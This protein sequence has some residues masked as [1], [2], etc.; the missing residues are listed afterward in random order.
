MAAERV[1]QRL[2]VILAADVVG[3]SCRRCCG[4]SAQLRAFR[5]DLHLR[6]WQTTASTKDALVMSGMQAKSGKIDELRL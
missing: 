2:E 5:M 1:Q 3:Y 6:G 4:L